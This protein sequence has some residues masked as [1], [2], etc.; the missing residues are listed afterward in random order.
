[1]ALKIEATDETKIRIK[2]LDVELNEVYCRIETRSFR[3][4]ATM[5]VYLEYYATK[6]Q[7]ESNEPI[8]IDIPFKGFKI[9]EMKDD[10]K[11]G[12]EFAHVKAIEV[13]TEKGYLATE[14]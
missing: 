3:D 14:V 9:S 11:Q 4:G 6:E 7:Y 5:E 1:M 10:E 2:G 8:A 13:F 12:I